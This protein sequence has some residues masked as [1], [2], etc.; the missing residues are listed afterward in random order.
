MGSTYKLSQRESALTLGVPGIRSGCSRGFRF[1][2]LSS[3]TAL[4]SSESSWALNTL[5]VQRGRRTLCGTGPAPTLMTVCASTVRNSA[6]CTPS[7]PTSAPAAAFY[8][9]SRGETAEAEARLFYDAIANDKSPFVLPEQAAVVT[10][11]LEVS[12]L[13]L[14]RAKP[15]F[16]PELSK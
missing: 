15:V 3:R 1:A 14:P 8:E 6:V 13:R 4:P 5:Y 10:Q 2:L 7:S 9:G 12:T 11:I 16:N